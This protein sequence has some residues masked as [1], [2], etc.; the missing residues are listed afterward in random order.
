MRIYLC[1]FSKLYLNNQIHSQ[2]CK[3]QKYFQNNSKIPML[4]TGDLEFGGFGGMV[5]GT[6]FNTQMGIGATNNEMHAY[7]CG[8]VTAR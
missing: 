6:F 4:I 1:K 5:K 7:R 3:H 8:L 2:S